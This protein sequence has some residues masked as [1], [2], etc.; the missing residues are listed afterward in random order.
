MTRNEAI[1]MVQ[2]YG[3][4][5]RF[6]DTAGMVEHGIALVEALAGQL[7]DRLDEGICGE[8]ANGVPDDQE[9]I[10]CQL[11]ASHFGWHSAPNGPRLPWMHW[12]A[13]RI[14]CPYDFAHTYGWC[15]FE[16]CRES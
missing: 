5:A 6:N 1:K 16:G 15:G 7:T 10:V 14:S 8:V 12:G 3:R 4:A 2:D 13:P 9:P 11:K